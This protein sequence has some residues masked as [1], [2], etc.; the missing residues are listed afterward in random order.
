[1]RKGQRPQHGIS[2][3]EL[4]AAASLG[5]IF[6][7]RMLGLFMILPVFTLYAVELEG[8]SPAL[9]GL[10]IGA[11]GLTQ[12]L[13]QMP[14]GL[15]S[16][17]LGRKRVIIGGL[18]VFALGSVVAATS[19]TI[20]GVI[21]GRALQGGGAIAAAVMALL[22]DLTREEHRAKAMAIFGGA[23]GMSFTAALVL[24]PL[25]NHWIG[26]PGI[27]WLTAVLA[28]GGI[29]ITLYWVPDPGATRF[30]RDAEPVPAQFGRVLSDPQLLRLDFGILTLHMLITATF[31]TLP[32]AL[33]DVAGIDPAHHWWVY[34]P[35]LLLGVA[36]MIPLIVIAEKQA[37]MKEV[38]LGAIALL[39]VAEFGL[40]MLHDSLAKIL[41]LLTVFF[42]GFNV[43]E[44]TLPSLVSKL[45]PAD[46]KGTAMGVYSSSQF[47]GA[48]LGGGIGGLLLGAFG[49]AGVFWFCGAMVLLWL[50]VASG[51]AQ[52]KMLS[53]RVL[54][55]RPLGEEESRSLEQA[56]LQ[57]PGVTEAAAIGEEG[58]IYLKYYRERLDESALT[59]LVA[60]LQSG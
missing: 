8:Y 36:G 58:R 45:A 17:R 18:L 15:L 25:F 50:L 59:R 57:L 12:A 28:L 10:A 29:L 4:R 43:L 55:I 19:E 46:S 1:M 24:G 31:V 34:L 39:A 37:R 51:M 41:V 6:S 47:L 56:L 14:F 23:I 20:W 60:P 9:A 7:L 48:F 26:V 21:A 52:P 44:A 33:R 5:S 42:L 2:P 38:F 30:H 49:I 32:L 3:R 54:R 22:A 53:R 11:Y 16:D 35:V 13:L 40:A 27:F